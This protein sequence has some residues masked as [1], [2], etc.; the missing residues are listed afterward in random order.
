M[1]FLGETSSQTFANSRLAFIF[2]NGSITYNQTCVY[3]QS[4]TPTT[5][6]FPNDCSFDTLKSR[7]HNTLQLTNDQLMDE[8]YY[9]QPFIDDVYTIYLQLKNDDDVYTILM[10]NEQYSWSKTRILYLLILVFLYLPLFRNC[11]T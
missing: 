11:I 3:F 10:C 4:L 9:R 1:S 8:I 5:M 7:M 2:S 6:R